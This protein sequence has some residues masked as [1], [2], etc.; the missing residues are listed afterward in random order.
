LDSSIKVTRETEF[1][2]G[3]IRFKMSVSNEAS[4]VITDVDLDF[5][6]DDDMLRIDRYEPASYQIKNGKIILGNI[7]VGRSKSIA[8]LFQSNTPLACCGDG[9]LPR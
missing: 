6:F 1:Y 4:F 5:R 7:D 3:F 9:K 8:V 2:Q